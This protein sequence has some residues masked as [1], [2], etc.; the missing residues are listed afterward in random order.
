M[1]D[2]PYELHYWPTIQGRGEFVR[3][4]LE[5]AGAPYV[6]V[7]R[8]PHGVREMMKILRSEAAG[9]HPLAPPFLVS[10]A[11][12]IAQTPNILQYLAPRHGLVPDDEAA[13]LAANQLMLTVADLVNE[14]HDT[15]HPI[16]TGLYYEDQKPEAR[17]RAHG[18][19]TERLPKFL[20]YFEGILERA[21]GRHQH[22][23]GEET[24]YVDLA[25]FQVLS[26]L[27]YA[28][29]GAMNKLAPSISRLL[30]SKAAVAARPR[31]AA[32]LASER[33][34]PFNENGIFRHYPELDLDAKG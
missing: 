21:K 11:L 18:F 13:R 4:A 29:P 3:L 32:Y 8:G 1:T 19:V 24:S 16:G 15:H 23:I 2:A 28:F 20:G 30:A 7:A 14:V 10:G 12:L 9:V 6:D 34:L 25:M 33:R 27:D 26:G 17:K 5:E 31:I 22:F